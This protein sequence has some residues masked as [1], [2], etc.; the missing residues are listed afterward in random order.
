MSNISSYWTKHIKAIESQS[1]SIAEYARRNDLNPQQIYRWRYRLKN[2]DFSDSG[3]SVNYEQH[4]KTSRFLAVELSNTVQTSTVNCTLKLAPNMTLDFNNLPDPKWL[5]DL[6][7]V[8]RN[9]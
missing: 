4:T 9:N 5:M 1:I 2:S 8:M 3:A 6:V 7:N